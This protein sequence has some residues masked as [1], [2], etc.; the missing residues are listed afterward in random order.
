M[1]KRAVFLHEKDSAVACKVFTW[2]WSFHIVPVKGV[3][4]TV[5]ALSLLP[6]CAPLCVSQVG[7][8]QKVMYSCKVLVINLARFRCHVLIFNLISPL[9]ARFAF[10]FPFLASIIMFANKMQAHFFLF[11]RCIWEIS[12]C[13]SL[14]QRV[15]EPAQLTELL[16]S[17]LLTVTNTVT[18]EGGLK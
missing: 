17:F 1:W 8:I 7:F 2:P 6:T 18:S 12:C 9:H 10:S 13:A 14:S 4:Q 3:N 11:Q 15:K 16:H 5:A